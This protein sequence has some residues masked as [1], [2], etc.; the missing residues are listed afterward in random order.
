NSWGLLGGGAL[1]LALAVIGHRLLK[2]GD[3]AD[4]LTFLSLWGALVFALAGLVDGTFYHP[5]IFLY[6]AIFMGAAL[7]LSPQ[8]DN[9]PAPWA[10][11][12]FAVLMVLVVGVFLRHGQSVIALGNEKT[13]PMSGQEWE[14]VMSFP[15]P[16]SKH[17]ASYIVGMNLDE[18]IRDAHPDVE[19]R[20]EWA[21]RWSRGGGARELMVIR[22]AIYEG[23]VAQGD[24]R[25][26]A[27]Y[28][29]NSAYVRHKVR[30]MVEHLGQQA[31][32]CDKGE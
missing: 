18:N 2:R 19:R 20:L 30:H 24:N 5:I 3:K 26:E 16:M 1:M 9:Q 29:R 22:Q 31:P 8:S 4:G 12:M 6:G 7:A 10:K 17:G 27:L 32:V 28:C 14:T 21:L 25:L 13:V 11:P 23:Q 15:S